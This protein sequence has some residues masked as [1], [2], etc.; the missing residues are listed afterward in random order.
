MARLVHDYKNSTN[1]STSNIPIA[2]DLTPVAGGDVHK[3][4][5]TNGLFGFE[6]KFTG[7]TGYLKAV[8]MYSDFYVGSYE[9]STYSD[10]LH[11][12]I[13][14]ALS[15]DDMDAISPA[16]ILYK[17]F[18]VVPSSVFK[19]GGVL[20]EEVRE[21][22]SIRIM[23]IVSGIAGIAAL[24]ALFTIW[25]F[26][27][28]WFV[29]LPSTKRYDAL[30]IDVKVG[31]FLI[32][33]LSL[34]NFTRNV[35]FK[36]NNMA[37]G[38]YSFSIVNAV[39]M[40]V[41]GAIVIAFLT[42][43]IGNAMTRY[44][45]PGV[46]E[47]DLKNSYMIQLVASMKEVFLNRSIAIQ[48]LIL[49]FGFFFAGVGFVGSTF[50]GTLFMIYAFC[51][52]FIGLPILFIYM[53]RMGYLSRIL[54]AT[55][56]M[57]AGKLNSDIQVIGKSP[58][59]THAANLNNLR[60]G[61]ESSISSQAKSERLKTELI[62]N[63][64]HDLRTPLTSII[65]YTD[66]LKNPNLS[67]EERTEYVD[68]L[69]RKSQRLKTLIEDLFEVSKMSSGTMELY[70][71][72]VD[73]TQLVQQAIGEHTE[74]MAEIPLDFRVSVPKEP[75]PAVI[76]GQRW[77]RMLDNLIGNS[78]KYSL[79]GTR[80]FVTLR[81]TGGNAELVVKNITAYELNENVDELYDRFK[82]GDASR[83]TDGS[84]LGLAIA[85]SIVEMHGGTM[86]IDVDGDLFKVTVRVP[87]A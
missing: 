80:V 75:M 18:V 55:E 71:Q 45:Q 83:H 21:H 11:N 10:E 76:D 57:A 61:V 69:D 43:Q 87:L 35:S 14:V 38:G 62:T 30:R 7:D 65:T 12:E 44:Q 40:F 74:K 27:W 41:M 25:K 50:D 42:F 49:L 46:F 73:L 39:F 48:T 28:T 34:L 31:I 86:V 85:Q 9:V 37:I 67:D 17:G 59:A 16:T 29:D 63:V 8:G 53:R 33:L 3:K 19:Q 15:S 2:Y 24:I 77:W 81:D 82:R 68:V 66:L 72:R 1:T 23:L 58:F 5:E 52:L 51:V 32:L 6:R 22:Q 13:G 60:E 20:Y 64:S 47:R 36:M 70:K 78:L 54:I 79:P 4:W 56:H 84:G 26:K